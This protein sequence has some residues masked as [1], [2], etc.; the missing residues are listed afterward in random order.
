MVLVNINEPKIS[1]ND[2]RNKDWILFKFLEKWKGTE[3]HII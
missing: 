3:W 1:E 2:I